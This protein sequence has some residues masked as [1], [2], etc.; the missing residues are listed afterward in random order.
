MHN[1]GIV[2][3]H[4]RFSVV[5]D[6]DANG[7][8]QWYLVHDTDAFAALDKSD[9]HRNRQE[10][11]R[12]V[13]ETIFCRAFTFR[14][15]E[16]LHTDTVAALRERYQEAEQDEQLRAVIKLCEGA[17]DSDA[18][19]L[20]NVRRVLEWKEAGDL[21]GGLGFLGYAGRS[22]S[23]LLCVEHDGYEPRRTFYLQEVDSYTEGYTIRH[24][25]LSPLAIRALLS[26]DVQQAM[27]AF[28]GQ[29]AA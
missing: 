23:Y 5:E 21:A 15:Y 13:H 19:A 28:A 11:E 4:R 8:A 26:T 9:F 16:F 3:R 10:I 27:T 14:F 7:E 25:A 29:G 2:E 24:T 12:V 18:H 20:R 6:T 1:V 17:D 22:V